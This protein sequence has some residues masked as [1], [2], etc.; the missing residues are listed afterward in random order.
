MAFTWSPDTVWLLLQKAWWF[1]VVLGV[2]V[3]FH[4]L[5]HFLAA[6]WVGVKV[7]KFSLGF[8]PKLFGRQVGE[9]EYLLSAIPLGGY[10]K[11][12][13]EDETEATT[14]EDRARS[15]AHQG[16]WGKVLIVAAGPGF[17]F[18]LAYFI[19]AGWLATGAPLFVPTFQDLTPDIEAM[20]PGSP[21]DT[22]GIQIG[23]RVSRVNGR[24]ISTRTELFDAVA[25]SNGQALTLE[26]KRGEQ[27]KTLTVTPTTASGPQA[28]AQEPGYYLGVEETPPLVTSVMQSSPAAKAGLQAGDHVVNIEGQAI[29]TWSQM[30]GIVKENPNRPLKVEVLR[31]GHRVSLT[32]TPS[33]EKS[34]VNGQSVEVG[35]I[36]I[37]GPGR[38]IM[39]SSTPL[40]SLYDG[41]GATWGWTELTAIGLYKM[42]V[43]DI[44]SK[45]IGGPLT[46][47]NISGEAAAQGASSV[48]FLIAILSIN[49]GVLNLLPIPI[50]DGGHLLFFL[51]EGILRKPLGERQREVAQQ[52]G[53]VLLVGVM[54]FAFWNDLER[55][56]SR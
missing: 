41:L 3:A 36:G 35:K 42:V 8:G 23:D 17:N 52:A 39:R 47:A 11:L 28:S 21:A 22:A 10:V 18:I 26:I 49:L 48:I 44:S 5:G 40:L 20:V 2:L 46:I 51:I 1:L 43:G 37:S 32:V 27:V 12:F 4:E 13:G 55:I 14:H 16:L 15:F 25:K 19:F 54:I 53:L 7:L 33:A 6:R 45:N 38:S 31:E 24:D 50:L 9:T 56:F 29:H 30:T 34:M